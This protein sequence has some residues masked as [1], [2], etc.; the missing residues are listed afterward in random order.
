MAL[1]APIRV[2]RFDTLDKPRMF[3]HWDNPPTEWNFDG[4][5]P[6][7]IPDAANEDPT[8]WTQKDVLAFLNAN[9]GGYKLRSHIINKIRKE[10][11]SGLTFLQLTNK[12]LSEGPYYLQGR[13]PRWIGYLIGALLN[14]KLSGAQILAIPLFQIPDTV[15]KDSNPPYPHRSR[16]ARI[17]LLNEVLDTYL[18]TQPFL[19]IDYPTTLSE[20]DFFWHAIYPVYQNITKKMVIQPKEIPNDI[21]DS[22]YWYLLVAR[23]T[24]GGVT[25]GKDAKRGH[26][27][28]PI[29]M[30]LIMLFTREDGRTKYIKGE[31]VMNPCESSDTYRKMDINKPIPQSNLNIQGQFE[32]TIK[33]GK[34]K[35]CLVEAKD[36]E[37]VQGML[38]E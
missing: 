9:K 31:R 2:Y 26:F 32:F 10:K 23:R 17:K 13:S 20:P 5:P 25:G 24:L 37:M 21:L 7:I 33:R 15:L 11:I 22:L 34:R 16:P 18:K 3:P 30:H 28:L 8:E 1:S 36:N 19:Y 14:C 27:I 29:I 6:V 4:V 38:Y 35:L 12:R